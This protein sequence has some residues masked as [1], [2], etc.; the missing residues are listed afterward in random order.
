[1]KKHNWADAIVFC[2]FLAVLCLPRPVKA[3]N[4]IRIIFLH[5][6]TGHNLIEEGNLRTLLTGR[7]YAFFD[8]G[9]NGDGL[10]LADGSYTGENFDIPGD[11]TDPDGF[12]E[13]FSQPLTNPPE[14]AFSQLMQYDVIMFK[15]CFPTSNIVDEAQLANY[16]AWYT[17]IRARIDQ[18]PQKLFIALTPPPQVPNN[19]NPQEAARAHAF[20]QWLA[21]DEFLAGHANLV[22]FDFFSLLADD[23][24]NLKTVYRIDANDAHP[25]QRAN[26]EISPIFADFIDQAIQAYFGDGVPEVMDLPTEPPLTVDDNDDENQTAADDDI[27]IQPNADLVDLEEAE[28]Q[29]DGAALACALD[30]SLVVTGA[31]SMRFDFA[32]SAGDYAGC[33][34]YFDAHQDWRQTDGISFYLQSDFKDEDITL[35]V[36]SGEMDAPTPFEAV[37]TTLETSV[38]NWILIQL[39]WDAFEKAGWHGDAGLAELDLAR[40]TSLAFSI[41]HQNTQ[42]GTI[43]VDALRPFTA[44]AERGETPPDDSGTSAEEAPQTRQACPSAAIALMSVLGLIIFRRKLKG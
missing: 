33:G 6:S 35:L 16:K 14:N 5:H 39:D 13:L 17:A 10:R 2:V 38:D 15:S 9:Y 28:W 36:F 37:F 21:L 29:Q 26:Q 34:R 18:Y 1:M 8:H 27:A 11:N 42:N 19:T 40:I 22:V 44:E 24:H 30:D 20:A 7:G 3:Q 4:P 32:L 31:A 23:A 25:N 41:S 43:R 12:A